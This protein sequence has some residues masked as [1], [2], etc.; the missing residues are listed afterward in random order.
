MKKFFRILLIV[1]LFLALVAVF[2]PDTFSFIGY[3][4][5]HAS[6]Y[7]AGECSIDQR[8]NRL[9]VN[10]ISGQ[11]NIEQ[12]SGDEIILS[13][14]ASRSMKQNEKLH[15]LVENGTLYVKYVRSGK[16]NLSRLD[17]DLT[18]LLPEH[19]Q[20]SDVLISC[21]SANVQAELPEAE[22]VT[23]NSVSGEAEAA[24]QKTENVQIDTV[25]GNMLLRF[26]QA[27]KSIDAHAVSADVTLHL[28]ENAGFA[29]DMDSVSGQIGG[30]LA[31][32]NTGK[33]L[34]HGNGAC[35]IRMD[36]VSGDL[37]LEAAR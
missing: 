36:S 32:G 33:S 16:I 35:S 21:V 4:Y 1:V 2:M 14:T 11:V 23:I 24:L 28:P 25:S 13:E 19:L 5:D 34:T 26:A 31:D 37:K 10:W 15:W 9:D 29:A 6:R 7:T 27:P 17:K 18:I 8:V 12:H 20:L 30:R 22:S 3:R